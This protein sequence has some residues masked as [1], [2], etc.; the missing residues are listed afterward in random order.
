[1]IETWKL[2]FDGLCENIN[3]GGT[4]TYGWVLRIGDRTIQGNGAVGA[5]PENTNNFAEYLAL[6]Y[7]LIEVAKLCK[8]DPNFPGVQIFGDSKLVCSQIDGQWKIKAERLQKA[9]T[10]CHEIL[11]Q[12]KAWSISWI[13]REENG[14]ADD[15]SRSAYK[16]AT[17]L[18]APTRRK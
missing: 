12:I 15:M 10:K 17:G 7:G 11:K 6:Y 4:A 8:D 18:D 5:R 14:A 2:Y 1:M 9:H 13:P 3:P 16:A